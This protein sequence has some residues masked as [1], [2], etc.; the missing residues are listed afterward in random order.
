MGT[1]GIFTNIYHKNQQN[2]C[3]CIYIYTG[4]SPMNPIWVFRDSHVPHFFWKTP[5]KDLRNLYIFSGDALEMLRRVDEICFTTT[6]SG[7]KN[8][9][10]PHS[11]SR[12]YTWKHHHFLVS[13]CLISGGGEGTLKWRLGAG[14]W[15][16]NSGVHPSLVWRFLFPVVD[17]GINY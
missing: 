1:N 2:S 12:R 7:K 9:R 11:W 13:I 15:F 3:R 17:N 5:Q 4:T 16:G 6:F 14:W 8:T 10:K